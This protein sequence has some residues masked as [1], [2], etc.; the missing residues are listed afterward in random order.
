MKCL[1]IVLLI[2]SSRTC[3]PIFIKIGSYLT[4]IEQKISWH[5]F[6]ETRCIYIYGYVHYVVFTVIVKCLISHVVLCMF[7]TEFSYLL[8]SNCIIYNIYHI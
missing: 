8:K 5:V 7:V 6:F 1:S 3:L 2:V 4:E